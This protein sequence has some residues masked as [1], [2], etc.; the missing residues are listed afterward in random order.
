MA[1]SIA[2]SLAQ[3]RNQ[4]KENL[5]PEIWRYLDDPGEH[6]NTHALGSVRLMPRPLRNL[7]GG[8]TRLT[9][10]GQALDHPI[11]LA[12]VAYQKL[13]HPDGER[14]SAL[15]AS[16]QGGPMV[17]SSLASH[18]FSDIV[19][20]T[21]A[22]EGLTNSSPTPWF[23]LY[24]QAG[25]GPTL[26]LLNRAVIA[27]CSAVVLTVDAPVKVASLELPPGIE[28]INLLHASPSAITNGTVFSALMAQAPTWDDVAWLRK[29]TP[30]PLLLK[31]LLHPDDAQQA[32]DVGCDGVVV[33]NHGGRTLA[34]APASID[35][36]ESVVRQVNGQVP[37]LFDSGLR[38]GQDVFTALAFGAS[39]VLLGRP[40]IWALA[41]NG[42]L[43]VAHVIRL[44]RDELELTMALT[45]CADLKGIG[46]HCL[47]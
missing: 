24:W 3:Y 5:P 6:H 13:F 12:P 19:A 38:S 28:A 21:R 22:D 29:Q 41:A 1:L 9:L 17:I 15:A 2:D 23:Q 46:R 18:R 7:S 14:A 34:S 10:F 16:A 43:G 47:A 27:G 44:L 42:P 45:G 4:A 8:H 26:E 33:S 20:C 11:L 25:R 32:L 39:A 36:L 37:V 40:Y 35:C 31:G 30:L